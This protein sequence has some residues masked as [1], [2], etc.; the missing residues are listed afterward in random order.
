MVDYGMTP[1]QAL[2]GEGQ[3]CRHHRSCWKPLE[4]HNRTRVRKI[5]H[6]GRSD[7]SARSKVDARH[8]LLESCFAEIPFRAGGIG[9]DQDHWR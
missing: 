1:A 3:V 7:Y 6:E 8:Y 2:R 4:R 9:L 5:R